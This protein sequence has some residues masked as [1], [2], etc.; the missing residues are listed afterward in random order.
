[1]RVSAHFAARCAAGVVGCFFW[2]S[3]AFADLSQVERIEERFPQ[4]SEPEPFEV[5][6][7]PARPVTFSFSADNRGTDAYGPDQAFGA[8]TFNSLLLEGDSLASSLF[9]T[10]SST[11][12]VI[13]GQLVYTT[14]WM[15]GAFST[16][17][18]ASATRAEEG[19]VPE[20]DAIRDEAQRLRLS[21][22]VP[23]LTEDDQSLAVNIALDGRDYDETI[24]AVAVV[25]EATRV[26]RASAT[27]EFA[28]ESSRNEIR[29]E[30]SHGLDAFGASE[31]GDT[32]LTRVD[33]RPQFTKLQLNA[34]RLETFS[35]LWSM[36][37]LVA[38]QRGDG[39][40]VSNEEMGIGGEHIGRAYE[41]REITGDHALGGSVE[42]RY[43]MRN[44]FDS[45]ETLVLYAY[46]DG[47]G[48]WNE[49]SDPGAESDIG[50]ASAGAG[51]R[52]TP[53][54]DIT[55]NVELTQPIERDV[56]DKGNRDLRVR[57]A[58]S[59]NW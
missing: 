56:E 18:L 55:A 54:D 58:V 57:V 41:S 53:F 48:V 12:E 17:L 24:S 45:V 15:D 46:G 30:L 21:A 25:G 3:P 40:M 29:L 52:V 49:D 19:D 28:D 10:P 8:M 26:L 39:A 6:E 11:D 36:L 5:E 7:R 33:G 9:V 27:Y 31:N 37:V 13:F 47:G 50:L 42:L 22:G 1:M 38:A 32:F 59:A 51:V 43:T 35:S 16:S 20:F 34:S 44:V 2:S 23:L 4:T 14:Q